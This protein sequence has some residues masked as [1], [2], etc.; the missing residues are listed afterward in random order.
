MPVPLDVEEESSEPR[1]QEA[2]P[3][4]FATSVS[5]SRRLWFDLLFCVEDVYNLDSW[6]SSPQ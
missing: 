2:A 5:E 4:G 6:N 3:I 1:L